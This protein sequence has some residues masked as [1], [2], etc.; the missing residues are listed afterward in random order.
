MPY[1][2]GFSADKN[3]K[4]KTIDMYLNVI[5]DPEVK[6]KLPENYRKISKWK[7]ALHDTI[8]WVR[9]FKPLKI[10]YLGIKLNKHV[11]ILVAELKSAL[12]EKLVDFYAV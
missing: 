12:N 1:F 10:Q 2:Q 7:P 11:N 6:V 5:R 9:K 8:L 4:K 3:M